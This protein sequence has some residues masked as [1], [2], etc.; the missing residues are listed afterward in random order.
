[1]LVEAGAADGVVR[2]DT[3]GAEAVLELAREPEAPPHPEMVA[4]VA[5]GELEPTLRAIG[6][7][8]AT[9]TLTVAGEESRLVHRGWLQPGVAALLLGLRPG[10]FQLQTQDPS[11]LTAALVRLTRMAP[12]RLPERS[13]APFPSAGLAALTGGDAER[14]RAAL[15]EVSAGFAWHL[16]LAWPGGLRTLTAVD[17]TRGLHLADPRGILTPVSNTL[18]YRALSTLLPTGGGGG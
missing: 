9:L 12:R 2:L 13:P 5:T 6:A 18:V 15:A 14:R 8:A 10:L 7:P 17:G 4:L 16:E 1:M 3:E 11:Y